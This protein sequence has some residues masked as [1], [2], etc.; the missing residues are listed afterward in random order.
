MAYNFIAYME[1]A[2]KQKALKIADVTIWAPELINHP[3]LAKS[4]IE[5]VVWRKT[6]NIVDQEESHL[7]PQYF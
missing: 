3:K 1:F 5:L 6:K 2:Q 4:R 7:R